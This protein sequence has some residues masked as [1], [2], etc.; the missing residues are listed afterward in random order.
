MSSISWLSACKEYKLRH[1]VWIVPKTG[2]PEHKEITSILMELR[3]HP[4]VVSAIDKP[5]TPVYTEGAIIPKTYLMWGNDVPIR[6]VVEPVYQTDEERIA[7]EEAK[8]QYEEQQRI[9]YESQ[10]QRTYDEQLRHTEALN[11]L[12]RMP[13]I[14]SSKTRCK[15]TGRIKHVASRTISFA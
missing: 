14:L 4:V 2:T 10:E 15:K 3:G 12:K 11:E 9:L 6:N 5:V 13:T 1:G 7:I 8:L